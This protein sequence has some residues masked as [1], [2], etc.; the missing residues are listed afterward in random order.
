MRFDTVLA[1]NVLERLADPARF[2]DQ[3][4]SLVKVNGVVVLASTFSW[5]EECTG[6]ESWLG[7]Y[8]KVCTRPTLLEAFVTSIA[9]HQLAFSQIAAGA[10]KGSALGLIRHTFFADLICMNSLN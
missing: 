8:Y 7:G 9:S 6:K 4:S 2:L 3:L 5:S 10:C 1:A